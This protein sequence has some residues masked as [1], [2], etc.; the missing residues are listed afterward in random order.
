MKTVTSGPPLLLKRGTFNEIA[1]VVNRAKMSPVFTGTQASKNRVGGIVLVQNGTGEDLDQYDAL[2]IYYPAVL[3]SDDYPEFSNNLA[4]VCDAPNGADDAIAVIQ[5]PI[6]AG[7]FGKAVVAGL[8]P[9]YLL[10]E[11]GNTDQFAVPQEGD[12]VL[13]AD[14]KGAKILWEADAVD[15]SIRLA[16][17]VLP[18]QGGGGGGEALRCRIVSV[19][20]N[21]LTVNFWDGS[22]WSGAAEQ[23]AKP[24]LLRTSNTSRNG[25]TYTYSN[26][27]TRLADAGGGNT[28]N[29]TIVP[30]YFAGDEILAIAADSTGVFDVDG[31]E[32]IY[33][34]T[35]TEGRA[36][37]RQYLDP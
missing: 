30:S 24:Y 6:A 10:R 35:N 3:P 14:S 17:V 29:Q 4:L 1:S 32:F 36:W 23:I 13:K 21:T 12:T 8:T 16:L 18:A 31:G 25:I 15:D 37:A 9:V 11:A 28:E 26:G 7:A 5:E 27:Y 33:M 19:G 2:A 20:D 22:A 34:D